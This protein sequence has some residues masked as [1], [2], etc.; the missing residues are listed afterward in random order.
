MHEQIAFLLTVSREFTEEVPKARI[1][2]RILSRVLQLFPRP[3]NGAFRTGVKAFRIE[4]SA[5]IVVA[6]QT[7]I[8]LH[9]QI[10][11][12]A[13]VRT[14]SDDI[15]EAVNLVDLLLSDIFQ[16]R[17]EALE[18][19]VNVADQCTLHGHGSSIR[20]SCSGLVFS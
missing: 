2:L 3:E 1:L 10:D 6:D 18:I 8:A 13:R 5:L 17:L 9:D 4:Y 7:G 20:L 19:T 12:F 16:N 15:P 11:T 14:V